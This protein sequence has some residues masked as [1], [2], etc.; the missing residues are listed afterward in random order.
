MEKIIC[1]LLKIDSWLGKFGWLANRA[2]NQRHD[3]AP[4]KLRSP[5]QGWWNKRVRGMTRVIRAGCAFYTE[6]FTFDDNFLNEAGPLKTNLN[7]YSPPLRN[8]LT[9]VFIELCAHFVIWTLETT[10]I[11]TWRSGIL[12]PIFEVALSS[13]ASAVLRNHVYYRVALNWLELLS[14]MECSEEYATMICVGCF[15]CKIGVTY[16]IHV[17]NHHF[18]RTRKPIAYAWRMEKQSRTMWTR[19]VKWKHIQWLK[20]RLAVG[21]A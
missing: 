13:L 14:Q 10:P 5:P 4:R 19:N 17:R 8:T 6:G 1:K 15:Y 16:A 7:C 2:R 18:I 9:F 3:V 12:V 21:H 20:V 11:K